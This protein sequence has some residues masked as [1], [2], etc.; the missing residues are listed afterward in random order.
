MKDN[1]PECQELF[2]EAREARRAA[3]Q[4]GQGPRS[5]TCSRPIIDITPRFGADVEPLE[6]RTIGDRQGSAWL[7]AVELAGTKEK[8]LRAYLLRPR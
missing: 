6:E 7:A 5:D 4:L 2:N 8:A 1:D 3:S